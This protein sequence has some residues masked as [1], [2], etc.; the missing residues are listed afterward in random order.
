MRGKSE[1]PAATAAGFRGPSSSEAGADGRH[2][3]A[4][5]PTR[6]SDGLSRDLSYGPGPV[7]HRVRLS[8]A[9]QEVLEVRRP[10]GVP[11]DLAA[12]Q[13]RRAEG[14]DL[15]VAG[16]YRAGQSRRGEG[17]GGGVVG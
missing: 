7:D 1:L 3:A 9:A 5:S 11:L 10:L 6:T 13:L 2:L 14:R 15:G 8:L 17:V 12:V 4:A 16:G